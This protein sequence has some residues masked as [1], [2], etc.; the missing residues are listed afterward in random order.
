MNC[1]S[2]MYRVIVVSKRLLPVGGTKKPTKTMAKNTVSSSR[3]S[4]ED[5]VDL[6]CSRGSDS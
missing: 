6:D 1:C 5:I 3:D 2:F 4:L